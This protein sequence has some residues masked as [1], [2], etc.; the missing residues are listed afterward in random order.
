VR[1]CTDSITS[2]R[3]VS[4]DPEFGANQPPFRREGTY[5]N[6]FQD[7]RYGFRRLRQAPGFALVCVTTLAL[8]IGVNTAIFTLVDAV[9]LESLPVQNPKELYRLGDNRNCWPRGIDRSDPGAAD[10][11]KASGD[12]AIG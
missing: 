8:R 3:I 10:A 9:M 5:D 12:C 4:G 6:L 1:W 7:L 2:R 11:M